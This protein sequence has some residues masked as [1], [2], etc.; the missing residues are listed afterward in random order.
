MFTF[1]WYLS[2]FFLFFI[3]IFVNIPDATLP[4]AFVHATEMYFV[5]AALLMPPLAPTLFCHTLSLV[6]AM[7]NIG[8][9]KPLNR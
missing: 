8:I 1:I 5:N 6:L 9:I 2:L 4:S 3:I 7:N